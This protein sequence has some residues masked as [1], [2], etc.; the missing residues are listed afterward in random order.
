L[1]FLRRVSGTRIWSLVG[2]VLWRNCQS[3]RSS[4]G[5]VFPERRI[6]AQWSAG[7]HAFSA[8]TPKSGVQSVGQVPSN[9]TSPGEIVKISFEGNDIGVCG[10][11]SPLP[12]LAFHLTFWRAQIDNAQD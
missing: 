8:D 2:T 9:Q 10:R 12:P 5:I 1:R 4:G 7:S 11:L 6:A 3:V